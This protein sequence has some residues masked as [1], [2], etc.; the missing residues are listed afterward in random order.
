MFPL[1][2]TWSPTYEGVT[3]ASLRVIALCILVMGVSTLLRITP[4]DELVCGLYYFTYPLS[5][6]G[7][8]R[9]RLIARIILTLEFAANPPVRVNKNKNKT[10]KLTVSHYLDSMIERF[11]VNMEKAIDVDAS[12]QELIVE[13]LP[14]PTKLEWFYFLSLILFFIA[15]LLFLPF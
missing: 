12:H 6:F 9:E 11:S 15:A 5:W 8:P 14:P 10:E 4:R 13:L 2:D 7:V 3:L 1:L